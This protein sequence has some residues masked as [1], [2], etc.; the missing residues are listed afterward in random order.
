MYKNGIT[1]GSE[2]KKCRLKS[3]VLDSD[4]NPQEFALILVGC[5]RIQ[6]GKNNPQKKKKKGRNS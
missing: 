6:M 1:K 3:S 4:P 2:E 5:I